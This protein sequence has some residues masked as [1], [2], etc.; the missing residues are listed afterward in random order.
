MHGVHAQL[1]THEA[2]FSP[3]Y[4]YI[5]SSSKA[6]TANVSPPQLQLPLRADLTFNTPILGVK[7][8]TEVWRVWGEYGLGE[9]SFSSLSGF[10]RRYILAFRR[11]R[12]RC[13]YT[14][15]V[16][17][18]YDLRVCPWAFIIFPPIN[19]QIELWQGQK[20]KEVQWFSLLHCSQLPCSSSALV[21]S[22]PP[23]PSDSFT[24]FLILTPI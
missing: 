11:A 20:V 18:P 12:N 16:L 7:V 13:S 21:F 4:K 19:I 10:S 24:I 6:F 14:W 1:M 9:R 8:S 22:Q 23:E 5:Q 15:I 3:P 2:L 17:Q